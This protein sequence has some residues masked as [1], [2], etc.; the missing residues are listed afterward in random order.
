ML[1]LVQAVMGAGKSG[2]CG[3]GRQLGNTCRVSM[4]QSWSRIP[5]SLKALLSGFCS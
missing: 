4:L 1:K 5:S 3:A 2:I